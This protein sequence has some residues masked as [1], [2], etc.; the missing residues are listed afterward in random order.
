MN[1]PEFQKKCST[2][3]DADLDIMLNGISHQSSFLS[4]KI[5]DWFQKVYQ[6]LWSIFYP[7]FSVL[8]EFS[9]PS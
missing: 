6:P 3:V 2:L 7:Y 9:P 1:N 5:I 8:L 4:D